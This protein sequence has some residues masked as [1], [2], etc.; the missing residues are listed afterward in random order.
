M[1]KT[2]NALAFF[3]NEMQGIGYEITHQLILEKLF[4]EPAFFSAA[5][6]IDGEPVEV[7]REP[8][9]GKFDLSVELK[10][11]REMLIE[12]KMW[13]GLKDEQ[14]DRQTA[15]LKEEDGRQ[16]FYL[17]LGVSNYEYSPEMIVEKSEGLSRK[18]SY[19]DLLRGLEAL[20]N[21]SPRSAIPDTLLE[22]YRDALIK[23]RDWLRD[24][25]Q[26][27]ET[28]HR[29]FYLYSAYRQ[30]QDL[31][32][33]ISTRMFTGDRTADYILQTN[34]LWVPFEHGGAVGQVFLEVFNGELT[35]RFAPDQ[36]DKDA[37][38]AV[39]QQLVN[40]VEQELGSRY[41]DMITQGRISKWMKIAR[42]RLDF[43]AMGIEGAVH[44][45]QDWYGVVK[46]LRSQ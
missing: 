2:T 12:M 19:A 15:H 37:L 16:G 20:L 8:Y 13:S 25:W 10:E 39:R 31:M 11:G 1:N 9:R 33:D 44:A 43:E 41:S 28:V 14:I 40:Y 18:L 34:D 38:R 5:C 21:K 7:R 29:H 46:N 36:G 4:L 45:F 27:P 17:L 26:H 35:I 6:G 30:M 32:P 42:L 3:F 22:A 23:Q 24:A